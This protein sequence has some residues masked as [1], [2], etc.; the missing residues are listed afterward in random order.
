M[1]ISSQKRFLKIKEVL[2]DEQKPALK[3]WIDLKSTYT[4]LQ[5]LYISWDKWKLKFAG[6]LGK[7]I[8]NVLSSCLIYAILIKTKLKIT[9]K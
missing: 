2:Q 4:W 7:W 5:K 1:I 9:P 6:P 3:A 8:S